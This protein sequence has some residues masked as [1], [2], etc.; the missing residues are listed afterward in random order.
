[1][2]KFRMM[3]CACAKP[4]G[5]RLIRQATLGG[6]LS[7][8]ALTI[9][10]PPSARAEDIFRMMGINIGIENQ[11]DYRERSPLVVPPSR[12]LP[13][14]QASGTA[15]NP[16]WP[17]DADIA[18]RKELEKRKK[19]DQT[20]DYD[21]F[22]KSLSPSELGPAGAGAGTQRS[23]AGGSGDMTAPLRPSELG[24]FGFFGSLFK[25]SNSDQKMGAA[26]VE[27]PRRSLTEPPAGYQTPSPNQ[28]YAIT[29]P[30]DNA[31]AKKA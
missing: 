4:A 28:P 19:L 9:L 26:V 23:A 8:L 29:R 31:K 17:A 27:P 6:G 25:G 15:R 3:Q 24:S 13:P 20:F 10:A 5:M 12:E 30:S 18:R 14:P 2:M 11:I 22:T 1:M 7:L 21:R 16:N